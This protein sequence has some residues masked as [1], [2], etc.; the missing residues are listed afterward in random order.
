MEQT[1]KDLYIC[2]APNYDTRG[3]R[4]CDNGSKAGF[5]QYVY[6]QV[7][8]LDIE[9]F[10]PDDWYLHYRVTDELI[11][12][13]PALGASRSSDYF[14]HVLP[15]LVK[16]HITPQNIIPK[17]H[18]LRRLGDNGVEINACGE[19]VSHP[20]KDF[21]RSSDTVEKEL[22]LVLPPFPSYTAIQ[23]FQGA[24]LFSQ[25]P[26]GMRLFE[27]FMQHVADSFYHPLM[28]QDEINIYKVARFDPALDAYVNRCP[29][30]RGDAPAPEGLPG[31]AF[32]PAEVLGNGVRQLHYDMAPTWENFEKLVFPVS[33][34]GLYCSQRNFDIMTL[35]CYRDKGC[36]VVYPDRPPF[37]YKDVLNDPAHLNPEIRRRHIHEILARDFPDIRTKNTRKQID[38]EVAEVYCPASETRRGI[39][40]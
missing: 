21:M 37:G 22:N 11:R 6:D 25:N 27:H 35:Q 31:R 32:V 15:H 24:L 1:T 17:R 12:R 8:R 28:P 18:A 26:K 9:P 34:S 38:N 2:V 16:N 40:R 5:E 30:L 23:T 10:M 14:R 33:Q 20:L 39:K 13:I 7:A 3:M 36:V 19:T 29:L 4:R